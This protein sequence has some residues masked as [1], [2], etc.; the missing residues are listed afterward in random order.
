MSVFAASENTRVLNLSWIQWGVVI[1]PYFLTSRSSRRLLATL[2]M[3]GFLSVWMKKIR[4]CLQRASWAVNNMPRRKTRCPCKICL[5]CQKP[6]DFRTIQD[7]LLRYGKHIVESPGKCA[8]TSDRS[9]S[10]RPSGSPRQKRRK[11]T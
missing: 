10:P 11:L 1:G 4:P 9:T 8:D 2:A 7:H 3:L 5:S 6:I